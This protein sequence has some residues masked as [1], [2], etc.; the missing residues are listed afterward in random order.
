MVEVE[1]DFSDVDKAFDQF[2]KEVKS[3]MTE[4][5]E[6]G[7]AYAKKHGRYE[8]I[9]GT[10]R[11]SNAYVIEPD[12]LVLKNETEYATYV[13]AKGF[14]VLGSAALVVEN[15]LKEKCE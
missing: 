8:D 5:G 14:D 6:I 1:F 12:G 3:V 13:E 9:T 4:A 11:K 7:V 10:L 15:F 2:N